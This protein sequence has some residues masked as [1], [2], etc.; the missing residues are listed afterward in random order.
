MQCQIIGKQKVGRKTLLEIIQ[1]SINLEFTT[2]N[3]QCCLCIFDLTQEDSFKFIVKKKC[4]MLI[5]TK[6]DLVDQRKVKFDEASNFAQNNQMSYHEV[7]AI[8]KQNMTYLITTLQNN[9]LSSR[10]QSP[11]IRP[12]QQTIQVLQFN[13]LQTKSSLQEYSQTESEEELEQPKSS[14]QETNR[15]QRANTYGNMQLLEQSMPQIQFLQGSDLYKTIKEE[16]HTNSGQQSPIH[17][18]ISNR[19]TLPLFKQTSYRTQ[20]SDF[21]MYES[22]QQDKFQTI[23]QM[24]TD[25]RTNMTQFKIE[26]DKKPQKLDFD[27]SEIVVKIF[28]SFDPN[29]FIVQQEFK[30]QTVY[31]LKKLVS[32]SPRQQW[33]KPTLEE[34]QS[35]IIIYDVD[36]KTIKNRSITPQKQNVRTLNLGGK[37][38][39][40]FRAQF[41]V[42]NHK[43]ISFNVFRDDNILKL[44]HHHSIN[45]KLDCNQYKKLTEY[46][47]KERSKYS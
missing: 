21:S 11:G 34:K 29:K 39:R 40:L 2:Q 15:S 17:L 4:V 42:S 22:K 46:L 7:S 5:G 37:N 23:L 14:R 3:A 20:K 41:R 25:L 13:R 19:N 36:T 18:E 12:Q 35:D 16:S 26:I 32:P 33:N 28:D 31:D 30:P 1:Q 44:A 24:M 45:N 6:I 43:L 8:T 47:Q 38:E 27:D 9:L 10:T